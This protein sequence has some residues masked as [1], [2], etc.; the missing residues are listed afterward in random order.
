MRD[1]TV[2]NKYK[3][4]KVDTPFEMGIY[5]LLK[6]TDTVLLFDKNLFIFVDEIANYSFIEIK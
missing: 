2:R 5:I 6:I 1:L 3:I 4:Y